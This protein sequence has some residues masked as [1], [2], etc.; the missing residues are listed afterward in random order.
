MALEEQNHKDEFSELILDFL[1]LVLYLVWLDSKK[2][3]TIFLLV[4]KELIVHDIARDA[5]NT[6]IG[7][8]QSSAYE[9]RF[10]RRLHM[11]SISIQSMVPYLP[12]TAVTGPEIKKW[13]W[14][15]LHSLLPLGIYLQAIFFFT[16]CPHNFTICWPS[17]LNS[18]VWSISIFPNVSRDTTISLNYKIN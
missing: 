11:F 2:L 16:F 13:K 5:P 1:K 18:K 9:S 15:W 10:S 4:Q 12:L 8:P 6:T 7:Y 17:G 3:M 14:K